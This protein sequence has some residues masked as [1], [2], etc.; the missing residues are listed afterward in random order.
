VCGFFRRHLIYPLL[1][2]LKQ[3]VTPDKLALAVALGVTLGIFPMLGS[4][5]IL[6]AL[7]TFIVRLNPVAIQIVNYFTYPLQILLFMPFFAAGAALFGTDVI[8]YTFGEI[9]TRLTE[10]PLETIR[11]LW[12]ANVRAIVVWC[13]VAIPLIWI[14]HRVLRSAF[15]RVAQKMA[16][17]QSSN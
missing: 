7:A 16:A 13:V 5:T 4:T 17:V 1:A 12:M 14:L 2:L 15:A 11:L 10:Q 8:P 6:C 3:G 9:V